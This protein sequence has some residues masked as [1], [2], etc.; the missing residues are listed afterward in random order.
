MDERERERA[1]AVRVFSEAHCLPTTTT[2]D[3]WEPRLPA[4]DPGLVRLDEVVD[5][6]VQQD[7][8]DAD[9]ASEKLDGVEGFSQDQGDSDNDDD[10]LGGVGDGLRDGS[11]LLEGEGGAL[12]VPVEPQSGGN[13]VLPDGGGGLDGLD[14][15]SEP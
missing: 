14:E 12:V 4:A 5:D 11:G 13:E 2:T 1:R 8:S 3:S 7:S 15:L 9:G 6:G 10:A